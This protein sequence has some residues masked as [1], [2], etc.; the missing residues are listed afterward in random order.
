MEQA[1]AASKAASSRTMFS[2]LAATTS[3]SGYGTCAWWLR[4]ASLHRRALS[5]QIHGLYAVA[6][7]CIARCSVLDACTQLK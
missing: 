3:S 1:C 6:C 7:V 5:P 4:L 2:A